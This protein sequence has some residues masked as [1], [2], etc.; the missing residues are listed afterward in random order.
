MRDLSLG[1][2]KNKTGRLAHR[3]IGRMRMTHSGT[4]PV[5]SG[6]GT[7]KPTY[8]R[9]DVYLVELLAVSADA[10]SCL[11][12]RLAIV[13]QRANQLTEGVNVTCRSSLSNNGGGR[14]RLLYLGRH[15]IEVRLSHLGLLRRPRTSRIA[16]GLYQK[17]EDMKE[18]MPAL[19]ILTNNSGQC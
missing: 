11:Y 15:V 2:R 19:F 7:P 4:K 10:V 9:P 16:A 3:R 1:N 5:G 18:S 17:D 13:V 12:K 14:R 8:R 6:L